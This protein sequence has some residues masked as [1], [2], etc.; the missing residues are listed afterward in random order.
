MRAQKRSVLAILISGL[1]LFGTGLLVFIEGYTIGGLIGI[2]AGT[3]A[4][5]YATSL[6]QQDG[7]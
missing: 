4:I 5:L 1:S 6:A 7:E 2:V 3:G